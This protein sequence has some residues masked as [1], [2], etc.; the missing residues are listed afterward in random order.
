MTTLVH[1][2]PCDYGQKLSSQ[3]GW[4]KE[5]NFCIYICEGSKKCAQCNR[6]CGSGKN[7]CIR[8]IW[9]APLTFG[10]NS[11]SQENKIRC[12][13]PQVITQ[14]FTS[15]TNFQQKLHQTILF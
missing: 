7:D 13:M 1:S 4:G 5:A 9:M 14:K 15:K 6:G 3:T 2:M 11:C 12:V 8:N 10:V